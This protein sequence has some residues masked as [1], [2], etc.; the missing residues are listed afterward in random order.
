MAQTYGLTAR[1]TRLALGIASGID[2]S[3]LAEQF[4]VSR[5]TLRAQLKSTLKKTG[6]AN[7][8][9]LIRLLM[10]DPAALMTPLTEI[11][12]PT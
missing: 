1:E 2:L 3:E 11:E 10:E 5:N 8:S 12:E 6:C 9:A 7:Q 4:K